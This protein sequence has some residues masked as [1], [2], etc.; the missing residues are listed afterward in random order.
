MDVSGLT[1]ALAAFIPGNVLKGNFRVVRYVDDKASAAQEAALLRAFRGE[2]GGPLA[3][4]A[5]LVGEEVD[6]P[7]RRRSFSP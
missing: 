7:P 5:G 4:L 2:L 3:D 6:G 1:F